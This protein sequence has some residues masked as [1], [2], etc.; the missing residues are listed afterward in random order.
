MW[1]LRGASGS[2]SRYPNPWA[3]RNRSG[4]VRC[5]D[6]WLNA[7]DTRSINPGLPVCQVCKQFGEYMYVDE[8]QTPNL[9]TLPQRQGKEIA[10]TIGPLALEEKTKLDSECSEASPYAQPA[11]HARKT[12]L[13]FRRHQTS[14]ET[15]SP[16]TYQ[17]QHDSSRIPRHITRSNNKEQQ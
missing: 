11:S 7:A 15:Q 17:S 5:Q 10:A 13:L 2:S 16:N 4:T 1:I 6:P 8:R 3:C 9:T 14:V 12:S